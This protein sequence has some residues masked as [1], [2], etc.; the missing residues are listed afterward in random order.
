MISAMVDNA[1]Q[2][3]SHVSNIG[4]PSTN[5]GLLAKLINGVLIMSIESK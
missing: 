4:I 1:A 2:P 5:T 3:E